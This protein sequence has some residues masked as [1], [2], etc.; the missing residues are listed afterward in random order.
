M[1]TYGYLYINSFN[2]AILS[3]NLLVEDDDSAGGVQFKLTHVLQSGVTYILVVTTYSPRAYGPFSVVTS[4]PG[5]VDF[6]ANSIEIG[7]SL[8]TTTS[9][10]TT[11][12]KTTTSTTSLA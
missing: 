5:K 3:F 4:G 9:T 6:R 7:I 8:T 1:D 2:K 11:T 10:T 12:T